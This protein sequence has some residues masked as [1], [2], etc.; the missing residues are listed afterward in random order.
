[1]RPEETTPK[2]PK[3]AALGAVMGFAFATYAAVSFGSKLPPS[4]FCLPLVGYVAVVATVLAAPGW[5]FGPLFAMG[6]TLAVLAAD[7]WLEGTVP[8]SHS[9][10]LM[11]FIA[12]APAGPLL[13]SRREAARAAFLATR[14]PAATGPTE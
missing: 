4:L 7:L 13:T 2:I 6:T 5:R 14:K 8:A 12:L 11:A 10:P 3:H 9:Y 1:M